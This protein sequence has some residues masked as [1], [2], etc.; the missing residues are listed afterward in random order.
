MTDEEKTLTDEEYLR[1]F[2]VELEQM[3][4]ERMNFVKEHPEFREVSLRDFRVDDENLWKVYG[5]DMSISFLETHISRLE[6]NW[7]TLKKLVDKY[8]EIKKPD[9][10]LTPEERERFAKVDDLI[11]KSYEKEKEYIEHA[12]NLRKK[13]ISSRASIKSG[14]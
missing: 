14:I 2:F 11:R 6:G 5:Y 9:G 8:R 4:Y 10:D 1:K 7:N 12:K 3:K 13:G